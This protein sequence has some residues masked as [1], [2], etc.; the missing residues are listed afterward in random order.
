MSLSRVF[1]LSLRAIGSLVTCVCL[2]QEAF[3]FYSVVRCI[4][5]NIPD[6][7]LTLYKYNYCT[8]A[9]KFYQMRCIVQTS[10]SSTIV[11]SEP[12]EGYVLR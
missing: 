4:E 1:N 6:P 12:K 8:S 2:A 3:A 11:T 5:V 7:F 10:T 9:L